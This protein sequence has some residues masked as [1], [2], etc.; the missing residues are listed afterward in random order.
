MNSKCFL[1]SWPSWAKRSFVAVVLPIPIIIYCVHKSIQ[2]YYR[3]IVEDICNNIV[4]YAVRWW[5]V[6]KGEDNAVK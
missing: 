4:E 3:L 5:A 2:R 1:D 6:V